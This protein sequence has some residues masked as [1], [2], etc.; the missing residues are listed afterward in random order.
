MVPMLE[1]PISGQNRDNPFYCGASLMASKL[2]TLTFTQLIKSRSSFFDRVDPFR[3]GRIAM[4][5]RH[6]AELLDL[7]PSAT[8]EAIIEKYLEETSGNNTSVDPASFWDQIAK[9][10]LWLKSEPRDEL[11]K[12]SLAA[13]DDLASIE[14]NLLYIDGELTRLDEKQVQNFS[15]EGPDRYYRRQLDYYKKKNTEARE[16]IVCFLTR[17]LRSYSLLAASDSILYQ[18]PFSFG[19]SSPYSYAT[20]G[21]WGGPSSYDVRRLNDLSNKFLDLPVGTHKEIVATRDRSKSEFFEFAAAY[22]KGNGD[23][24]PSVRAKILRSVAE[25]H[26][27]GK[28]RKVIEI[29]LDHYDQGD[30][31]SFVSMASLQI[32]GIFADICREIGIPEHQLDASSLNG[33]LEH[34]EG[35][36]KGFLF[37]EYYAFKF[38]VLRN[39]VAHGGLVDGDLQHTAMMLMLDLLPVCDLA[40]SDDLPINRKLRLLDALVATRKSEDLLQWIELHATPIPPY[41]DKAEQVIDVEELFEGD[42]FWAFVTQ[43]LEDDRKGQDSSVIGLVKKLK[44]TGLASR[45]C[46]TFLK[47][48]DSIVERGN[49]KRAALLANLS[50]VLAKSPT[51]PATSD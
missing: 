48:T 20:T 22:I 27:L 37:F 1:R 36:L 43:K 7:A 18:G 35:N 47:S 49:Q 46:S 30:Y 6:L 24:L 5:K 41:Y 33:K 16:E 44:S 51:K 38:P 39:L 25:S 32:E 40:V 19:L 42:E 28:R 3:N 31:L 8:D 12:V 2:R 14:K 9:S 17:R 11:V 23:A 50:S 13:S 34:I 10:L 45:R 21:F 4:A 29:M 15:L 26:L